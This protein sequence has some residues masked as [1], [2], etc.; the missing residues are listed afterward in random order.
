MAPPQSRRGLLQFNRTRNTVSLRNRY[1]WGL[2]CGLYYVAV[3][4]PVKEE[5][6]RVSATSVEGTVHFEYPPNSTSHSSTI[7]LVGGKTDSSPKATRKETA[8]SANSSSCS[9]FATVDGNIVGVAA[10][11]A[12]Q[13][14]AAPLPLRERLADAQLWLRQ[15]LTNL[16]FLGRGGL[17]VSRYRIWKAQ[18]AIAT[19]RHTGIE[20][21]LA[22][23]RGVYHCHVLA[24][25]PEQ[26]GKGVG[27]RLMDA[28]AA[29]MADSE[30]LACY[31]ESSKGEPNVAIY[32]RF[33]FEVVEELVCE[34]GGESC[35]VSLAHVVKPAVLA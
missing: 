18:Q 17:R 28:V 2:H 35:T 3:E 1:L 29:K 14:P 20:A 6:R 32:R 33:G 8:I 25:A 15:L 7:A 4:V 30:G 10:W 31:L 22:Y 12:P 11:H 23:A 34:E 16:R 27:R 21:G 26:Q 13:P 19:A 5:E 24:V 9:T